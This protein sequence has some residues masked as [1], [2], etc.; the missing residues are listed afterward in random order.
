M[1]GAVKPDIGLFYISDKNCGHLFSTKNSNK[2]YI[3]QMGLVHMFIE[4]KK[5]TDQDAFTDPP[6]DAQPNWRFTVDTWNR[7]ESIKLRASTLGQVAHYAHVVQTRQFRTCV[8]SLTISGR[9]ARIMRWDRSGVLVTEAFDYKA[10]PRTLVDFVWRFTKAA[11]AELIGS[12]PTAQSIDSV[13]DL[14]TFREAITSHVRLQLAL[15]PDT[16]EKDLEEEVNKHYSD[17]VLTRLTIGNRSVWVSRPMWVSHAIVGRCTVGY[18]G[19]LCDT[20]EVVFVK[21]VWR[22]NVEGV[23]LEGDILSR[24]KEKGVRQ[25]PTVICHGDV[26]CEGTGVLLLCT[27]CSD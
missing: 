3:A 2:T 21:D 6:L 18:W 10:S 5:N 9:M 8:F 11:S 23:E 4:V 12:D 26:P 22:T 19:V 13:T 27:V 25:I 7:E 1:V 24:L 14:R 15:G 16:S 17:Q 20:K